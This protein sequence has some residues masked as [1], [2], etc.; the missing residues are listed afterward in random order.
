MLTYTNAGRPWIDLYWLF[1]IAIASLYRLGG[2]NALVLFKAS[3]GTLVV[4]LALRARAARAPL[5]PA[6]LVWLPAVVALSALQAPG[7]SE[8]PS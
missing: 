8:T 2:V 5:W 6:V 7:P 4:A 1:Q 3:A